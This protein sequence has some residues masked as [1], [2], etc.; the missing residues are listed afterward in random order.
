VRTNE[1][2][3]DAPRSLR[4]IKSLIPLPVRDGVVAR[5]ICSDR[6]SRR[7]L[8]RAH[9]RIQADPS[10]VRLRALGGEPLWVRPGTD[11]PW[12]VRETMTYADCL[13]PAELGEPRVILDLGAN[14]GAS[15]AL[16]ATRFP[17]ARIIGIE[18]DPANAE[19]CRQNVRPWSDRCEVVEVAAWTTD[20]TVRLS[21]TDV[22]ALAVA[23]TGRDVRA[24]T[25]ASLLAEYADAH[26]DYVKMDIEGAELELLSEN[27]AWASCV[28]C[29]SVEVHAP[30][31]VSRCED[32]LRALDFVVT[33]KPAPRVPRVVGQRPP[34]NR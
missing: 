6:Q 27:T 30:Y 17:R 24:M 8:Q 11:D 9:Q 19:L 34:S 1:L 10:P 28:R 3:S 12:I 23:A 33:S 2:F 4:R 21:G 20:G 26:A 22:S 15:M 32:D 18:P 14:I 25:I 16:L 13:P 7:N 31:T 29:V 5:M